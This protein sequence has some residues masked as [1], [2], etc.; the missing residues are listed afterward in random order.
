MLAV[1]DKV[2]DEAREPHYSDFYSR[3]GETNPGFEH[4]YIVNGYGMLNKIFEALEWMDSEEAHK[5]LQ[6]HYRRKCV[7]ILGRK[8]VGYGDTWEEAWQNTID[9]SKVNPLFAVKK[10]VEDVPVTC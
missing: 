1:L 5:L 10:Y 3:G 7:L 6:R 4:D 8:V 2:Q 9:S